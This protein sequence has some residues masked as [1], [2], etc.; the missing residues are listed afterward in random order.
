MLSS[1]LYDRMTDP[2]AP[3][4]V[5]LATSI[6]SYVGVKGANLHLLYEATMKV[7]HAMSIAWTKAFNN[8]QLT[9]SIQGDMRFIVAAMPHTGHGIA[10]PSDAQLAVLLTSELVSLFSLDEVETSFF[11][12]A[13]RPDYVVACRNA[14][15]ERRRRRSGAGTP[16]S[17]GQQ[18]TRYG[19][20]T[21]QSPHDR[22]SRS[23]SPQNAGHCR[24]EQGYRGYRD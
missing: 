10:C 7:R 20:N 14:M 18:A 13:P 22:R 3:G 21:R 11:N 6:R 19:Q 5:Q 15:A 17:Q 4:H 9:S 12:M 23:R 2:G 24:P 1:W 8:R 16:S